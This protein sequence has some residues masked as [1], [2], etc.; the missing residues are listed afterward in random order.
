MEPAATFVIGRMMPSSNIRDFQPDLEHEVPLQDG[1]RHP[2]DHD[3]AGTWAR[4]ALALAQ[5]EKPENRGT[6]GAGIRRRPGRHKSSRPGASWPGPAPGAPVTL[7][8]CF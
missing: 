6:R 2:I 4:V 1:G 7:F 3:M 8:N 5:A